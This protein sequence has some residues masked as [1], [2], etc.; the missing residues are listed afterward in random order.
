MIVGELAAGDKDGKRMSLIVDGQQGGSAS[1][2]TTRCTPT[3]IAALVNIEHIAQEAQLRGAPSFI[4][5][6]VNY[7]SEDE[8]GCLTKDLLSC[9]QVLDSQESIRNNRGA[10][11]RYALRPRVLNDVGTID[12]STKILGGRVQLKT[13]ICIA[14]FGSD[15]PSSLRSS[16]QMAHTLASA[17]GAANAH[18]DGELALARAAAKAKSLY[19]PAFY[20]AHTMG[21]IR[22]AANGDDDENPLLVQLYPPRKPVHPK[23][24]RGDAGLD[25]KY[26]ETAIRHVA[27]L[28]FVGA[29][30]TVDTV[31]NSNREKSYKNPAWIKQITEECGGFPPVCLRR[32]HY[33]CSC[34]EF[35]FFTLRL[36]LFKRL[37]LG[38]CLVTQLELRGMT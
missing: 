38:G 11:A 23:S 24:G 12:L 3:E 8:V 22:A 4:N 5:G 2:K 7:G 21:E 14:P 37:M 10:F 33:R 1:H 25:R 27:K 19:C 20:S 16:V 32:D 13:P 28:G 17:A 30:I 9:S 34:V 15:P 29:I 36:G 6:Y 35:A 26:M 31:N 18:P